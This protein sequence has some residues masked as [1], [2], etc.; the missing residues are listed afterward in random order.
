VVDNPAPST[1]GWPF[2]IIAPVLNWI[3]SVFAPVAI[4]R[5]CIKNNL[6]EDMPTLFGNYWAVPGMAIL[7]TNAFVLHQFGI[8]LKSDPVLIALYLF[9]A[10]MRLVFEAYVLVVVLGLLKLRVPQGLV[11]VCYTIA[12]VYAPLF[13]WLSIP[14]S[15]HQHAIL[16]FIKSQNVEAGELVSYFFKNIDE[17][18][19][20]TGP[21]FPKYWA[22]I[23]AA[24]W[25]VNLISGTLI[26][27]CITQVG[28]VRR[29]R[30]YVAVFLAQVADVI[31]TILLT[32]IQL[33]I[34]FSYMAGP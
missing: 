13:S 15:L 20:S 26:A 18:T 11:L 21:P 29:Q 19:R 14:A 27:E 23:G 22:E 3:R 5:E 4:V 2:T 16:S 10:C 34:T 28:K 8:E 9:V 24:N 32:V 17:I 33:F 7:A 1:S 30:V 31:P 25:C 12:V 6:Q